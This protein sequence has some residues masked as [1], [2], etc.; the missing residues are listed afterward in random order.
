MSLQ[1]NFISI[2]FGIL[3]ISGMFLLS[4]LIY[5]NNSNNN[6]NLSSI[7]IISED[8]TKEMKLNE[9]VSLTPTRTMIVDIC[10]SIFSGALIFLVTSIINYFIELNKI[11]DKVEE[12]LLN[13]YLDMIGITNDEQ[14]YESNYDM[15]AKYLDELTIK[16]E[17]F[18]DELKFVFNK[19]YKEY[20]S[21]E[22]IQMQHNFFDDIQIHYLM[23]SELDSDETE[24]KIL[25]KYYSLMYSRAQELNTLSEEDLDILLK[26]YSLKNKKEKITY[27]NLEI[28]KYVEDKYSVFLTNCFYTSQYSRKLLISYKQFKTSKAY[29]LHNLKEVEKIGEEVEKKMAEIDEIANEKVTELI[30]KNTDDRKIIKNKKQ[31]NKKQKAKQ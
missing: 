5:I 31:I 28:Y 23:L 7:Y 20:F 30:A 1:K 10:I 8:E 13:F 15:C 4:H 24:R 12:E 9:D 14:M 21:E 18:L 22:I 11:I 6:S 19:K 17:D 27:H 25:E 26:Q 3:V 2:S 16:L 29:F